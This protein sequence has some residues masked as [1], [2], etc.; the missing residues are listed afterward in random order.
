MWELGKK[1]CTYHKTFGEDKG[2]NK[3]PSMLAD[4]KHCMKKLKAGG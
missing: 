2:Y 3:L 1:A 4:E